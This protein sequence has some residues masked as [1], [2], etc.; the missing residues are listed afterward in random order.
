MRSEKS[1]KAI[2]KWTPVA[3]SQKEVSHS[4]LTY[5][6]ELPTATDR[7]LDQCFHGLDANHVMT[8]FVGTVSLR[9]SITR[10]SMGEFFHLSVVKPMERVLGRRGYGRDTEIWTAKGIQTKT[11]LTSA[12]NGV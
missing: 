3:P 5:G 11:P 9:H 4:S 1:E 10:R 12:V 6:I 2:E 7:Q 8:N